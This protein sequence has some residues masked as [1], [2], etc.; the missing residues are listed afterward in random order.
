MISEGRRLASAR[1]P[2]HD[3]DIGSLEN[4]DD[5]LRAPDGGA[6]TRRALIA[7]AGLLGTLTAAGSL[8]DV[9]TSSAA[10]AE[11][12]IDVADFGTLG[13]S[14]DSATFQAALDAVP[15]GGAQ[16]VAPHGSYSVSNLTVH[17]GTHVWFLAVILVNLAGAG[18]PCLRVP[19]PPPRS[20][21]TGSRSTVARQQRRAPESSCRVRTVV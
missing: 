17:S 7:R 20:S 6:L 10:G 19:R 18:T 13:T 5:C 14:D 16:V 12:E 3:T 4:V 9:S 21:S 1:A 11:V 15:A 8:L 2:T